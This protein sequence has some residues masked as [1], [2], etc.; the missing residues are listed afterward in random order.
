MI[1]QNVKKILNKQ[2]LKEKLS[3]K[4]VWMHCTVHNS[5][6]GR[7]IIQTKKIFY[8]EFRPRRTSLSPPPKKKETKK[9][10]QNV[11]VKKMGGFRRW[12]WDFNMFWAAGA[13]LTILVLGA[14][15]GKGECCCVVAVV[16]VVA[17][18]VAVVVV[19][20][21]VVIV[22]AAVVVVI[23]AA[24]TAAPAA[25]VV[26]V[27]VSIRTVFLLLLL[28]LLMLVLLLLLLLFLLLLLLLLLAWLLC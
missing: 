10:F 4:S 13:A 21:V 15:Q 16:A 3:D 20:V 6:S 22:A 18:V 11:A 12:R 17:V 25:A 14:S 9:M 7:A 27:V 26:V 28:M 19:V 1:S 8:F 2:F 23:V 24:A 5:L